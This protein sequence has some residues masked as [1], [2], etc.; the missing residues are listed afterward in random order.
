MRKFGMSTKWLWV[1]KGRVTAPN[2]KT[3]EITVRLGA[4]DKVPIQA[5][6]ALG[7]RHLFKLHN[8]SEI[9]LPQ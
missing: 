5:T 8:K 4:G 7:W 3:T 2:T 6:T 1:F 9:Y